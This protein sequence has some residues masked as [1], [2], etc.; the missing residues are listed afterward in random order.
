MGW[1]TDEKGSDVYYPSEAE[2]SPT[3]CWAHNCESA[4]C[5]DK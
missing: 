3:W 2:K 4:E 5:E 1:G